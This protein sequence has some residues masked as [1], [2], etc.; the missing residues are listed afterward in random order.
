MLSPAPKDSKVSGCPLPILL[1]NAGMD[2]GYIRGQES[3]HITIEIHRDAAYCNTLEP[4]STSKTI[5]TTP[6]RFQHSKE[7]LTP[8][9]PKPSP[10]DTCELKAESTVSLPPRLQL[11]HEATELELCDVVWST[12]KLYELFE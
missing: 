2:T 12:C 7:S 3:G 4:A 6:I 11:Y 5:K 9:S 8:D 10:L 1:L